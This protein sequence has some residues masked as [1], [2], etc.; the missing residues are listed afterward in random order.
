MNTTSMARLLG[1]RGGLARGRRLSPEVRKRIASLGGHAR[2]ESIEAARRL[3][4]NFRY[5][6]AVDALRGGLPP[7]RRLSRGHGRLPGL[8]R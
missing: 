6:A 4:D 3:V 5:A 7:V 8:Y 1:R 2:R